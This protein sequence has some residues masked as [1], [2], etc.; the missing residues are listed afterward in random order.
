MTY[1]DKLKDVRWQ[2]IRLNIFERDNWTCQAS[3]CKAQT[4][5]L[6][7]HHLEY[8]PGIEPW[9]YP[10]DMLTSLCDTCH[11]KENERDELEKHLAT[12]LK[13]KGFLICDLLAMSCKIENDKVFT[14][15]LLNVLRKFQ[16]G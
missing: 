3:D 6:N 4:N 12:T 9:E 10:L 1:A 7:V 11:K 13:M 2:K 14:Q 16:D 5:T 15:T 8:I